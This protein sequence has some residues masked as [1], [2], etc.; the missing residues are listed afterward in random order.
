MEECVTAWSVVTE[1]F[2]VLSADPIP[3]VPLEQWDFT[4]DE[5]EDV[6]RRLDWR[7]FR[8]LPPSASPQISIL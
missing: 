8:E 6:L 1:D 4:I 3:H 7:A 2:P 5:G